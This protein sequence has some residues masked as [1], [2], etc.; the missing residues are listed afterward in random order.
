MKKTS[1]LLIVM[2]ISAILISA[3]S[4][5]APAE[6]ENDAVMENENSNDDSSFELEGLIEAMDGDTWTVAGATV[7]VNPAVL[8]PASFMSGDEIRVQ[9]VLNDDGSVTALKI[10]LLESVN[11]N[12]NDANANDDNSNNANSNEDNSNSSNT[13]S[14]TNTNTNANTN[15]NNNSNSNSNSNDDDDD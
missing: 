8:G 10:E 14:S 6:N 13:N 7:F 9:G 3:C 1:I 15:T 2:L 12:S 4:P 11:A 5:V